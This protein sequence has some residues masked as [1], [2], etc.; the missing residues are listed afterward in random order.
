[1]KAVLVHPG[2][3]ETFW[4]F[5]YALKFI[6]KKSAY[7]PLGLL[8]VAAMLPKEW[9]KKLVDMNVTRLR[10]EDL[11]GADL[12]FI[13]AMIIQQ[14]SAKEVISRC[15]KMKIKVVAGGTSVYRRI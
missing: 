5:K 2:C 7:P 9:E 6:S 14:T 8:T 4:S 10:D 12:V 1:M 11:E 3:S 13:S 15:K